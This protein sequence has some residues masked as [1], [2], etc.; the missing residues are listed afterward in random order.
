VIGNLSDSTGN[1][2]FALWTIPAN[3]V[4]MLLAFVFVVRRRPGLP[5]VAPVPKAA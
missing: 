4:A 2:E 5:N 3:A 1:L